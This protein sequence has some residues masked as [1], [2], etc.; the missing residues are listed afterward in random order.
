MK[1]FR[2]ILYVIVITC[3]YCASAQNI[4]KRTA[5][6]A[7]EMP[8]TFFVKYT[9]LSNTSKISTQLF[10]QIETK[11]KA[12][13]IYSTKEVIR[14][15]IVDPLK[16]FTLRHN[17]QGN[18]DSLIIW[19]CAVAFPYRS[20]FNNSDRWVV[21]TSI[22]LFSGSTHFETLNVDY[23]RPVDNSHKQLY[24]ISAIIL[25]CLLFSLLLYYNKF[26]RKNTKDLIHLGQHLECSN[27]NN[28]E[29][30]KK[31]KELYS[32]RWEGFNRL[33]DEYFNKKDA[34][35][36]SVRISVHKELER[37][38]TELRSTKSLVE[39]EELVNTYNNGIITRIRTQMPQLS[40]KDVAF[41]TYLYAGFSPKAICL[42]TDSKIKNFY[43]RRTRLRDKILESDAPDREEFSSKMQLNG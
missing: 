27:S 30:D 20:L 4:I 24:I 26:Q 7:P 32:G 16:P 31:I 1:F 28:A 6:Y 39:L 41:L 36:D 17:R 5:E 19:R 38:I 37:Q 2:I 34:E 43:N 22:G 23:V 42:F 25:T 15:S 14:D 11:N 29:F 18:S 21:D 35:T 12:F 40:N 8:D 33:C 10:F 9:G 3:C 13:E